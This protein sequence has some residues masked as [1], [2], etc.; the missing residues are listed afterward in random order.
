MFGCGA[1]LMS[2]FFNFGPSFLYVLAS[3]L[4]LLMIVSVIPIVDYN[5]FEALVK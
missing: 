3:F 1:S 5:G 2:H 4:F